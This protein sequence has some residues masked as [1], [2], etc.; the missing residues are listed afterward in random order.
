MKTG[1][2]PHDNVSIVFV[3]MIPKARVRK[4]K[5]DRRVYIQ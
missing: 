5:I 4:A 3:D 1:G 2:Y